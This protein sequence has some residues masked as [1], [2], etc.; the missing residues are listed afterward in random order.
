MSNQQMANRIHDILSSKAMMGMG[1]HRRYSRGYGDEEDDI[2][3]RGVRA[4]YGP[5]VKS[6]VAAKKN[7]WIKFVKKFAKEHGMT[8]AEALKNPATKKAYKQF[9]GSKGSK[10]T[11]GKGAG[12][13]KNVKHCSKGKRLSKVKRYKRC[14][15]ERS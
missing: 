12:T 1:R 14:I 9:K 13:P 3:G 11:K 6:E 8:Y 10:T 15:I 5:S 2:Y 7:P 4:G